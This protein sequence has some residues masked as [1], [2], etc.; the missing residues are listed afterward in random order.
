MSSFVYEPLS[1]PQQSIRVV[2]I[3]PYNSFGRGPVVCQLEQTRWDTCEYEALS[4]CWGK[5]NEHAIIRLGEEPF[6][7]TKDL[8]AAL[9]QLCLPDRARTLWIDAI[10]INQ[11]DPDER[12]VQVS[13][14]GS[15]YRAAKRVLV[16]VGSARN[17]TK[18]AF[19]QLDRL[20]AAISATSDAVETIWEEKGMGS[21]ID[22]LNDLIQRPYWNRAWTVQ[23]VV[24]ARD[25]VLYCGPHTTCFFDLARV[26]VHPTAP[27]HLNVTYGLYSYLKQ[28][29]ALRSQLSRDPALGLFALAYSFR[30]RLV[31]EPRDKVYA[32]IGLLKSPVSVPTGAFT[33]DYRQD[34]QALWRALSKETMARHRTLLPLAIAERAKT[35]D[36]SWCYDWSARPHD[37]NHFQEQGQ[38]FW[39]GG[40]DDPRYYPLQTTRF[41]AADGLEARIRIDME[42]SSVIA[43][44]GFT[45]GVVA[46]VGDSVSSWTISMGRPNY[47]QLFKKWE[48]MVGGPWEETEEDMAR[49]FALTITGSAWTEGPLDWRAWN[50][51]DY[52]QRPWDWRYIVDPD[53]ITKTAESGAGYRPSRHL[54]DEQTDKAIQYAKVRDDACE[55]RRMFLLGND[56]GFGL[57]PEDVEVGDSVAI[58]PGCDVPLVLRRRNWKRWRRIYD[59]EGKAKLYG[60][61]WKV[62][63]QAYIHDIMHYHGDLAMDI[64]RGEVKLEEFLID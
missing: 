37:P 5:K 56:K 42:A 35:L 29:F 62:L 22:C 39:A 52:A 2:R 49:K 46:A 50:T 38:L 63:G 25:A 21:W 61:T 10:C 15:I 9:A 60:S 16:W 6:K 4:Y 12:S 57:G 53:G 3:A 58:L 41:S 43:V 40:L 24:L 32:F 51:R 1:G 19:T 8:A 36:A 13:M 17:D 31:S 54:D 27:K 23:E 55:G 18:L 45:H 28:T 30:H 26:L 48:R 59:T 47:V 33:V 44:E 64:E 20:A 34:K 7:V 11:S 14:M